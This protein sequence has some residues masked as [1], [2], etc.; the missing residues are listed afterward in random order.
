MYRPCM[1]R[2]HLSAA[3]ADTPLSST[4]CIGNA[5]FRLLAT[6]RSFSTIGATVVTFPSTHRLAALPTKR[7]PR[8]SSCGPGAGIATRVSLA[9]R[10]APPCM[11][12]QQHTR[13]A[14]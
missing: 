13:G 10:I 6:C 11:T 9:T 1:N 2:N 14:L 3:A 12:D 8:S 4:H 7:E 5:A